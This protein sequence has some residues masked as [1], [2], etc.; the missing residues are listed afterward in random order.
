M[1]FHGCQKCAFQNLCFICVHLWLK[2]RDELT[3]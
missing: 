2:N 3:H 1:D